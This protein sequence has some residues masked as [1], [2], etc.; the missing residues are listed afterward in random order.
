MSK[1]NKSHV[2]TALV[3]ENCILC[4]KECN[5]A[6]VMNKKLT[7]NEA[8]KVEKM[9]KGSI[10]L[11]AEPCDECKENMEKAFLIIGID[12]E[13]S[14]FDNLPEGFYR[15]GQLIGV[16]KDIPF[17]QENIKS[18]VPQAIEMGYLFLDHN[19]MRQMGLFQVFEDSEE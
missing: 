14:D 4:M 7:K 17:V 16:K 2:G 19:V 18:L 9:H 3:H 5:E 6:I 13:K 12:E 8:Q 15:T 10:G 1:S 11:S